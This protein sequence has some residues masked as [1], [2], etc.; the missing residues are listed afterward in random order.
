[1]A[2]EKLLAGRQFR[3][4]ASAGLAK[5]AFQEKDYKT[6]VERAKDSARMGGGAEARVLLG[7]AY[8]KLEKFDEAK[9]AYTEARKIADM[10]AAYYVPFAP[11]C[12]ISPLGQMASCHVCAAVPNFL[13]LEWHWFPRLQQ[14]REF[15]KEGEIIE[16]GYITVPDRPGVGVEINDEA[17][18]KYMVPGTTWFEPV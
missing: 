13:A 4:A 7:D 5:I 12:C 18:K 16:K 15:V 11:H 14:W 9:K 8:F 2:F 6:A 10:A 17:A 3:G 1:V